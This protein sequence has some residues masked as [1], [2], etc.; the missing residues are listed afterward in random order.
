ML[1]WSDKPKFKSFY[2]TYVELSL[3]KTSL[4]QEN[5]FTTISPNK[6]GNISIES[7]PHTPRHYITIS[8]TGRWTGEQLR[9]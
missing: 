3:S 8:A 5:S 9:G 6:Q 2:K 7:T 4:S 1:S